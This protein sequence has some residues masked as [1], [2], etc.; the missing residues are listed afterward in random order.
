ME[1]FVLCAL[2]GSA[3]QFFIPIDLTFFK[4]LFILISAHLLYTEQH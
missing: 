3:F 2:S 4:N 1:S